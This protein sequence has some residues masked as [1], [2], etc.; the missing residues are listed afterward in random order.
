MGTAQ[1]GAKLTDEESATIAEFLRSLTG[2]QPTDLVAPAHLDGAGA[3]A[4]GTG[5][6]PPAD[7][8][9][10]NN[11]LFS[12]RGISGYLLTQSSSKPLASSTP[13]R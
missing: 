9:Q 3:A 1:L 12:G 8:A 5:R 13:S 7:A 4:A 10:K 11:T 2:E 6:S